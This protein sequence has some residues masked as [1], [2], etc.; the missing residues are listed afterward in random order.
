[1]KSRCDTYGR[2]LRPN[3]NTFI[4]SFIFI[5]FYYLFVIYFFCLVFFNCV[6]WLKW[7]QKNSWPHKKIRNN[8]FFKFCFLIFFTWPSSSSVNTRSIQPTVFSDSV[9]K[10]TKHQQKLSSEWNFKSL[11]YHLL[12]SPRSNCFI[13]KSQRSKICSMCSSWAP[14]QLNESEN[15]ADLSHLN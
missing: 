2:R 15:P 5:L 6:Q 8:I 7:K 4:I 3:G 11:F 13:L 12:N 14:L 1:M 10:K 9:L